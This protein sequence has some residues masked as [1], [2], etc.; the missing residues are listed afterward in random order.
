MDSQKIG[1]GSAI[2]RIIVALFLGLVVLILS[3]MVVASTN[4]PNLMHLG[5]FVFSFILILIL[6]KGKISEYGFKIG[7]N[8]RLKQTIIV[9]LIAGLIITSTTLFLPINPPPGTEDF[10]FIQVVILIWIFASIAEEVLSRGLVQSYL[11]PLSTFGFSIFELRISLPILFAALFFGAMHLGLFM[12]GLD[13]FS[14]WVIVVSAFIMGIIAGYYREK[15][16]SLIPA[17]IIHMLFNISGTIIGFI[18]DLI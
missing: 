7:D 1:I 16:Q 9:G 5:M 14:V 17:I 12:A 8:L 18:K 2:L 13:S 15:T 11:S 3:S 10:S 6:S 4:S